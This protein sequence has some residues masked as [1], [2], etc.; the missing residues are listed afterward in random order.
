MTSAVLSTVLSR[1]ANVPR[2]MQEKCSL[3]T[4][5]SSAVHYLTGD[6]SQV[7]LHGEL[8]VLAQEFVI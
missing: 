6:S 2:I 3:F 4:H 8:S 5:H 7:L 1:V